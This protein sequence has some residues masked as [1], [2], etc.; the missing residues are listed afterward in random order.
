LLEALFCAEDAHTIDLL[1]ADNLSTLQA[2][3]EELERLA[4]GSGKRWIIID[5]IQKVPALLDV[6]HRL[7]EKQNLLFALTGSSARNY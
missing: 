3:P 5:E 4:L 6:A 1:R 7:I 2:R